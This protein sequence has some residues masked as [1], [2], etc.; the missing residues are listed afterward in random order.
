MSRRA[1]D[2]RIVIRHAGLLRGLRDVVDIGAQRDHRLA[3]T[4]R[5]HPGGGNAGDAALDLEAFFFQ[6]RREV[7]RGFEFLETQFAEAEDAIDHH[8]RLLLHGVD[9]AHQ[10]GLHGGLLFGGN[11]ILRDGGDRK[12]EQQ[13]KLTHTAMLH[14]AELMTSNC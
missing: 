11:L 14:P 2:H 1:F 4:P 10:I 5:R 3:L 7:F 12:A 13:I 8:L 9:L 6:D